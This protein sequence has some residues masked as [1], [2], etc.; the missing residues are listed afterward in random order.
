MKK[1][2][3]VKPLKRKRMNKYNIVVI[4]LTADS[5]FWI[6][7][8]KQHTSIASSSLIGTKKDVCKQAIALNKDLGLIDDVYVEER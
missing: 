1:I 6:L 2:K 3:L 5:Y 4:Q 7:K 8:D